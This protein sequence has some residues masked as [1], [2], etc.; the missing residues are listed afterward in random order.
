MEKVFNG[1][2]REEANRKANEWLAGQTGLRGIKR[3][4]V[5]IGNKGPS[6]LDAGDW[7]VTIH[8]EGVD[9]AEHKQ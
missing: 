1:S 9:V 3:T 5:A 4:E 2:S 7:A 6:L 8:C